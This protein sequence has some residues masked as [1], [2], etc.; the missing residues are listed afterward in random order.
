MK[1]TERLPR[2]EARFTVIAPE[3]GFRRQLRSIDVGATTFLDIKVENLYGPPMWLRVTP[4]REEITL[5]PTHNS[6]Y[7]FNKAHAVF[8]NDE[9]GS[10][11]TNTPVVEV[12]A[13]INTE[14]QVVGMPAGTLKMW[15][16]SLD[17]H[18]LG[19]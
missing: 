12:F 3:G 1:D 6:V 7:L 11:T 15:D 2:V 18:Q 4:V 19:A 17:S 16:Y 5:D 9:G 10:E 8:I 13:E 14:V